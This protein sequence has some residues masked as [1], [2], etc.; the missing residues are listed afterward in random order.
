MIFS[1]RKNDKDDLQTSPNLNKLRL[2]ISE[3]LQ[4]TFG[5]LP[6][7]TLYLAGAAS[8]LQA[9]TLIFLKKYS[10]I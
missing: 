2:I 7:D 8:M 9:S 3:L 1:F 5:L 10:F 6:P 4:F